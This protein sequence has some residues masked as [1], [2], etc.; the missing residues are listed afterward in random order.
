MP[1]DD[2]PH[3]HNLGKISRGAQKD[4]GFRLSTLVENHVDN[5]QSALEAVCAHPDSIQC[6]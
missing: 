2:R 5:S 3:V 1:A 4:E 6:K